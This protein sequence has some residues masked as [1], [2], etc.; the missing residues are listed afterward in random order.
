MFDEQSWEERYR[1]HSAVWSGRPNPQLVAE[2]SHLATGVALD[3]G[4]GEGA[5]ALWL[6]SRGWQVTA[7]DF[8]T[9]ALQRGAEHADALGAEV[10]GNI[11][12]V[13]ADL[14]AWVPAE[15]YFDLVSA[16]FMHL[17]EVP[18]KA[19]FARL[20]TAV[21]PGGT[22]L[23]VGHHPSDMQTTM[24]RPPM[25]ELFFTAEEVADSLD[26]GQWDIL[27]AAA[28]PRPATDPEGQEVT[29]HDTVLRAGKRR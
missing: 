24:P 19:L 13:H 11:R 12:W 23:I 4:C 10:A 22:L 17:P 18:R 2:A 5:D 14:I 16:Q 20:A 29:I 28:R 1:S 7:V 3:V 27:V 8:S 21:A 26:L 9:T 25:P 6:A 15:G